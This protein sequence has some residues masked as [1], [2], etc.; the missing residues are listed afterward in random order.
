VNAKNIILLQGKQTYA[1]LGI[2]ALT[3]GNEKLTLSSSIAKIILLSFKNLPSS[4][5]AYSV[6]SDFMYPLKTIIYKSGSPKG[7]NQWKFETE[8][9][10]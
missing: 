10:S 9:S 1:S 6:N 7:Q 3:F 4:Q 5:Q 2:A 8:L